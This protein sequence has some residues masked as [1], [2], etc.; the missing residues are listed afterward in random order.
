MQSQT[1]LVLMLF[2]IVAPHNTAWADEYQDTI[3]IFKNAGE[4]GDFFAKSYAYA[5][6]PTVGKGGIGIG[7]AHGKGLVYVADKAVGKTSMTQLTLGFQLGGQAYSMIVFLEDQ[8]AFNEFTSGNFEFGAQAN[9]VAITAGVSAAA[10]TG[11]SSAGASGGKNDATTVGEFY[12]GMATFTVAK[13]GLMYEASIGGAKF[14]Y[15]HF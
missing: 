2:L 4:S 12:K 1:S 15:D 10:T 9:A 7:G 14:S 11:G 13:G 6:F 5:V 8:R 3:R